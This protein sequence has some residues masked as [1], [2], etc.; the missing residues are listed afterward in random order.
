MSVWIGAIMWLSVG[1]FGTNDVQAAEPSSQKPWSVG[2]ALG[3]LANTPDGAAFALNFTGDVRL[4]ERASF[5][6]L[7]Q[8]GFTGD[9]TLVGFSGQGK[10]AFP[11]EGSD[12]FKVLLQ[13][14]IGF[15]HADAG[16]S[17]TS[18]L[19]P[20]GVGLD[21]QINPQLAFKSDFLLNFTDL[22]HRGS[23]NDTNVMPS[24]TFGVR[25]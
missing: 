17:D 21:Y 25:F 20:L 7:L 3:Y 18:F 19:I 9:L 1:L 8:L 2:G 16:P 23:Y 4:N 5:G 10:Y 13:G 24:L 12:K 15:V 14:G 6:P 22:D 11:I